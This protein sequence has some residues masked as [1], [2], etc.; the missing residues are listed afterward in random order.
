MITFQFI[1]SSLFIPSL[2][3]MSLTVSSQNKQRHPN[4]VFILADDVSWDDFGCY[5]NRD[6]KTPNID[7]LASKGIRFTNFFLTASS[8]RLIQ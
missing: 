2:A 6:V 1:K 4:M 5:G 3:L 7:Q 8:C